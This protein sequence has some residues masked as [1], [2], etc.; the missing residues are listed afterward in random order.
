MQWKEWYQRACCIANPQLFSRTLMKG[1]VAEE[2]EYFDSVWQFPLT[3]LHPRIPQIR[4]SQVPQCLES[5]GTILN[6]TRNWFSLNVYQEIE[7]WSFTIWWMSG[8]FSV[9][10]VI[11]GAFFCGICHRFR[12]CGILRWKLPY[13]RACYIATLLGWERFVGSFKV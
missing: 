9:E 11:D 4:D 5:R 13:Q 8:A 1:S 2:S 12:R 7:V 6:W 3:T 10:S